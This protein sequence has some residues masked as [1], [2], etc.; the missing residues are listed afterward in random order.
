MPE[1]LAY[2]NGEYVPFPE[3]RLHVSDM[4]IIQAAMVTDMVRTFGGKPFELEA[5]LERFGRS[6]D[7]V[8]FE[9]AESSADLGAIIG[10]LVENNYPLIPAGHDL[11][12]VLFATAGVHNVYLGVPQPPGEGAGA[13]TICVHTMPLSFE[14]WAGQ[15]ETGARLAVPTVRHIAPEIIDPHIKYRS[16]LHWYQADRQA[17]TIDPQ[18]T[19]LLL[20]DK[21]FVTETNGANFLIARDDVL[22]LPGERTTLQGVSRA[23]LT[24]MAADLGIGWWFSDV[25][26]EDVLAADEAFLASTPFCIMPV[27]ALD[28]EPIAG[29]QPGPLFKK[30]VSEWSRRVGVDII[31]QARTAADERTA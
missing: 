12:I 14:R 28:N 8:G 5:H 15:Y 6:L 7:A 22:L 2:L 29:G 1:P 11:G 25:T 13:R 9:L 19:A 3:C 26:P 20:D 24:R 18:A 31:A 30:L 17:K 27:T 10:R 23:F 21:G 4:G 16:R